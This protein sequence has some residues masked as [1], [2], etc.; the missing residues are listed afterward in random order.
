ML[1]YQYN[2]IK[3]YLKI[4]W[5]F[6]EQQVPYLRL[7]ILYFIILILVSYFPN[8]IITEELPKNYTPTRPLGMGGAFVGLANDENAIWYN[9]SGVSRVRK[10]RS[11]H[12][13]SYINSPNFALGFNLNTKNIYKFKQESKERL[14]SII[15]SQASN[16][17]ASEAYWSMLGFFPIIMFDYERDSPGAAGLTSHTVTKIFVEKDTPTQARVSVISDLGGVINYTYTS[18]ENRF[19]VGLQ[20]RYITRYAYED[21]ISL[22]IIDN[23]KEIYNRLLKDSNST[24][25]FA[26]DLGILYTLADFWFPTIGISV[27]NLP[28]GCRKNYLN[29]FSKTRQ[30]VCGTKYYGSISNQDALSII[31]PTD[32]KIGLSI[33]PRFS[34]KIALRLLG[35]IHNIHYK[36]A[37]YHYGLENQKL[38]NMLHGGVEL[39]WGNPLLP[40]PF[41]IRAGL[42]S[43]Y[44]SY[45]FSIHLYNFDIEF[46]SYAE[47]VSTEVSSLEDRRFLTKL[48]YI[49]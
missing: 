27:M 35:D 40:P 37:N 39:F 43:G 45:G 4:M 21:T 11:Q 32:I 9:P 38:K 12:L 36:F 6:I 20:L 8:N 16:L 24:N 3:R 17:E 46:A 41:A 2:D 47:D 18:Q 1:K 13:I 23:T 28:M 44:T 31:D 5:K 33:T 19:S 14:S 49:F 7:N 25:A 10:A 26:I 34:R 29:P 22:D 15:S 42:G 48:S 30:T